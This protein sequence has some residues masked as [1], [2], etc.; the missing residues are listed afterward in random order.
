MALVIEFRDHTRR[1]SCELVFF[2]E[3]LAFFMKVAFLL[4]TLSCTFQ[5]ST[6][7]RV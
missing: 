5:V 4:Q 3:S 7:S 1:F 2:V 6:H